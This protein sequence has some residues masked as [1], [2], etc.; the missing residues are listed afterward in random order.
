VKLQIRAK[1]LAVVVLALCAGLLGQ[2]VAANATG[3]TPAPSGTLRWAI[4]KSRIA[5]SGSVA[6]GTQIAFFDDA[7]AGIDVNTSSLMAT[8]DG[9]D[10]GVTYV[11]GTNPKMFTCTTP[12]HSRGDVNLVMWING[13]PSNPLTFHYFQV[14]VINSI[15]PIKGPV[16]GGTVITIS[17]TGFSVAGLQ[18]K[19]DNM[20]CA[21]FSVISDTQATCTSPVGTQA[22]T[23]SIWV[24]NIADGTDS[25]KASFTYEVVPP[26][27]TSA[28]PTL[29]A[30][31]ANPVSLSLSGTALKGDPKISVGGVDCTPVTVTS[32]TNI[33]CRYIPT[34]AG[35]FDVVVTNN[36]IATT[37]KQISV[38][39]GPASVGQIYPRGGAL[40]GGT[41]I[42]VYGE[43]FT[44]N[45]T[46]KIGTKECTDVQVGDQS[47][48]KCIVPAGI[49]GNA[50]VT[51]SN[52]LPNKGTSQVNYLYGKPVSATIRAQVIPANASSSTKVQ[53]VLKKAFDAYLNKPKVLSVAL[54]LH[55][56][57]TT[58]ALFDKLVANKN[59]VSA[60]LSGTNE[61]INFI[62]LAYDT[63]VK[64]LDTR[65]NDT[66]SPT[67]KTGF[68]SV[69]VT[70]Q[71]IK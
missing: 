7:S 39:T 50:T 58:K 22:K 25:Q 48:L 61:Y 36:G 38:V 40:A 65:D 15:S 1:L 26:T 60:V 63:G 27:L 2:G 20:D 31:L 16:S 44:N 42:A 11:A 52:G 64:V 9:V 19:F 10:C 47:N 69:Y 3:E 17:G 29:I 6:G 28:S 41:Q 55:F 54:S 32:D 24:K 5:T 13:V 51:A 59:A 23:I 66:T 49:S 56:V 35:N 45:T 70:Y 53:A 37:A 30:G 14:P 21:A 57:A 71:Y 12:A 18:A 34:A 67:S 46:I 68:Y 4:Y 43:N 8:I 62:D 33:S